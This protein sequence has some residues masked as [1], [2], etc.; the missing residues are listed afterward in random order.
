MKPNYRG[1]GLQSL[2][3]PMQLGS[4][5]HQGKGGLYL[6]RK[7]LT[8]KQLKKALSPIIDGVHILKEFT[9]KRLILI[10]LFFSIN[11]FAQF[12][13]QTDGRDSTAAPVQV[14]RWGVV[15]TVLGEDG[16][17]HIMKSDSS[18][19][20]LTS[21]P[22]FNQYDPDTVTAT[23]S[24]ADSFLTFNADYEYFT[25][26]GSESWDYAIG[27]GDTADIFIPGG[28]TW[29]GYYT[30]TDTIRVRCL[31]SGRS[32]IISGVGLNKKRY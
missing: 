6:Y 31:E 13:R 32:Q 12:P 7:Y 27:F 15:Q 18:G 25:I 22:L 3:L 16:L 29:S 9:M 1:H 11:L 30:P 20:L 21:P 4:N 10:G 5:C 19:V 24:T 17:W 26:S 8:K 14:K 2:V 28:A 23:Y